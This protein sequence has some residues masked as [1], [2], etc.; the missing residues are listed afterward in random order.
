MTR[1]IESK[2]AF[3]FE[4]AP[5]DENYLAALRSEEPTAAV[6]FAVMTRVLTGPEGDGIIHDP[7]TGEVLDREVLDAIWAEVTA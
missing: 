4:S 6:M 2:D 5:L 1:R 7:S 3:D